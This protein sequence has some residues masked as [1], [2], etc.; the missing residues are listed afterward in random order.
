[1]SG[2]YIFVGVS[3][4]LSAFNMCDFKDVCAWDAAKT[5][6]CAIH[7]SDLGSECHV[8]LAMDEMG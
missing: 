1:M 2:K 6:I 3:T 4:G 5:E 8:L 7:V